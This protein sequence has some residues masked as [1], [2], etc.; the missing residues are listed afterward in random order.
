MG[1]IAGIAV[2]VTIAVINRQKL[3]AAAK[4]AEAVVATMKQLTQEQIASAT[5]SIVITLNYT[6]EGNVPQSATVDTGAGAKDW[7]ENDFL[8]ENL[9]AKGTIVSTYDTSDATYEFSYGSG[10]FL[11][12]GYE[13]TIDETGSATAKK[14]S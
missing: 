4:S 1:I 8:V 5:G 11:V 9:K 14:A 13:I 7:D 12:N 3:N 2:P 10:K 6:S